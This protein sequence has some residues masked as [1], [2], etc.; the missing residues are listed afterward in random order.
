MPNFFKLQRTCHLVRD[1][2]CMQSPG[3][4]GLVFDIRLSV[5]PLMG[6]LGCLA[7]HWTDQGLM[8]VPVSQGHSSDLPSRSHTHPIPFKYFDRNLTSDLLTRITA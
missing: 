5:T 8:D 3:W 6:H 4:L 7:S 1:Y 2:Q